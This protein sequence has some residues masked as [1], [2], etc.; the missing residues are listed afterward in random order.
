MTIK[1]RSESPSDVTAI[2]AVTEAAFLNA[3]HTSHTEQFIANALRKAGMLSVSL[4]AE[5]HGAIVGHVA[6]SP[7][8]ISDGSSGWYIL[9]PISVTPDRQGLGIGSQL[10]KQALTE[11]SKLAASGCVLVGNPNYYGRFGFKPEP[12]LVL[13]DVPPEYF[14]AISFGTEIPTGIVTSHEAF[15]A[16]KK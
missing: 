3:P 16:D 8:T 13:P 12:A 4:V 6:I 1:I 7:I 10:V 14:Q 11:L 15:N 2:A 9:G 5:D